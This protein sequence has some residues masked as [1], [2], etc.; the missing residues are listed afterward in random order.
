MSIV[1]YEQVQEVTETEKR[2]RTLE[3]AALEIEMRG[4]AKYYPCSF[5]GGVCA[6]GAVFFALGYEDKTPYEESGFAQTFG[7]NGT[8]QAWMILNAAW[9]RDFY[10]VVNYNDL[11]TTTASDVTTVL[12]LRAAEIRAGR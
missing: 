11:Y 2:A 10:D 5:S 3:A 7:L 8:A 9:G 1:E 4:H 12:R 6:G